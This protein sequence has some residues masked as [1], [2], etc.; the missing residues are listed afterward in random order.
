MDLPW[1]WATVIIFG[2]L[3]VLLASRMWVG[4][5]IG[6]IG[7]FSMIYLLDMAGVIGDLMWN[8][9]NN[10]VLACIPFFI[11][12]GEIVLRSGLAERL[13][14][15]TSKWTAIIPGGLIHTNIVSCAIFAAISGSSVATVATIGTVAYPEQM[16][17]GYNK[18][19]VLGSLT[20][21]GTLGPMIPPSLSMILYGVFCN[22]SVA[23]LF[24]ATAIPGIIMAIM[25]MVYI[26][27]R[28]MFN[29]SLGPQRQQITLSYFKEAIT[30][31]KDI[32]PVGLL[33]AIIFVGI[34]GGYMTPTEA[35][36]I[37][38]FVAVCLAAGFKK[39]NL[40][41]VKEASLSALKTTAMIM[42]ITVSAIVIA[43]V[44]SL[45]MIPKQLSTMAQAS[46]LP[47][48]A[49]WALL[50]V[51]YLFLGCFLDA[52]SMLYLTIAVVFPLMM[53]LGF[54]PIWFG[55]TLGITLET[56]LLT[57][58]VGMNLYVCQGVTKEPFTEIVRG[59]LPFFCV[60]LLNV[61]LLTFVPQLATWLPGT[62]R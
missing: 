6:T 41:T 52:I 43:N 10:Y 37:S 57:P 62:M 48:L 18:R 19:I 40:N 47:P 34:Y 36:A 17:R 3:I 21:G 15:G 49:I 33:I 31:L 51:M 61:M 56:G 12:M 28:V 46:G 35:A 24:V 44:L 26:F 5:A 2:S 20:A 39:L 25:F 54:D 23:K 32:W 55:V 4:L 16:G 29:P 22:V 11:F 9:M 38:G 30:A 7:V 58:P 8:V 1:A 53:S 60:M 45:L 42:L 59:S 14:R 27:I 50:V 13:Y